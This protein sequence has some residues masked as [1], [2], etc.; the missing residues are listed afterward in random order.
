MHVGTNSDGSSLTVIV[1]DHADVY[2]REIMH[3]AWRGHTT[4]RSK[5]FHRRASNVSASFLAGYSLKFESSNPPRREDRVKQDT[6][7]RAS[8]CAEQLQ[9]DTGVAEPHDSRDAVDAFLIVV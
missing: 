2:P 1:R 4:F 6:S 8:I 7:S 9:E 5:P 3:S